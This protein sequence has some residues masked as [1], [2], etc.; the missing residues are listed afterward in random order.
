MRGAGYALDDRFGKV[1]QCVVIVTLRRHS[2]SKNGVALRPPYG[3][4]IQLRAG[5]AR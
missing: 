1:E 2:R 5:S 3:A 4:A